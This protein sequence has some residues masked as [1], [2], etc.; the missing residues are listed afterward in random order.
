MRKH[1]PTLPLTAVQSQTL[2]GKGSPQSIGH[3]RGLGYGG[4]NSGFIVKV[5][6][7]NLGIQLLTEEEYSVPSIHSVLTSVNV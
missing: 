1:Q 2:P 6:F 5:E 3:Q 7:C 4:T